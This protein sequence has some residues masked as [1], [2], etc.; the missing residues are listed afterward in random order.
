MRRAQRLSAYSP[1]AL[2]LEADLFALDAT[3]IELSMSLFPWARWKQSLASVKLNVLLDLR[4]ISLFL[5]ACTREKARSG[6]ARRHTGVSGQLLRY[7]LRL[8][9]FCPSVSSA[10]SRGFF[11]HAPQIERPLLRSAKSPRGPVHRPALR[12]VYKLNSV[13]VRKDYPDPFRRISFVDPETGNVPCDRRRRHNYFEF[14]DTTGATH[15]GY[16]VHV[17]TRAKAT[18]LFSSRGGAGDVWESFLLPFSKIE[19]A[20][21]RS[22]EGCAYTNR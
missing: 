6:L 13:I 12:P 20:A 5:P 8:H 10:P 11:R 9:E 21:L 15:S 4:G 14:I 17:S 16:S 7:G 1:A 22:K 19:F 18:I 3:V 2:G